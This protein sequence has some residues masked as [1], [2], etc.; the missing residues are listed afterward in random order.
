MLHSLDCDVLGWFLDFVYRNFFYDHWI[1][2]AEVVWD[3]W[4]RERGRPNRWPRLVNAFNQ[5]AVRI[6]ET[7]PELCDDVAQLKRCLLAAR[8]CFFELRV[9]SARSELFGHQAA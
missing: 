9:D 2:W 4:C 5:S 7:D 6:I 3:D 8:R 1:V